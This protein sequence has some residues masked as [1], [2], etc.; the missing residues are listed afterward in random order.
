MKEKNWN[1]E[2]AAADKKPVCMQNLLIF[3]R[4]NPFLKLENT[5]LLRI[6]AKKGLFLR[7]FTGFYGALY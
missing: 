5:F 7:V 6:I 1:W 3:I 4:N 2:N